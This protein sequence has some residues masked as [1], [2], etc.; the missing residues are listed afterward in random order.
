[1]PLQ[2]SDALAAA[3]SLRELIE[4]EAEAVEA[5]STMT[6]KIVDGFVDSGL[7][8]LTTPR[9]FGGAEAHPSTVIDVCEELSFADGSVGWAY[10]QNITVGAYAAYMAPEFGRAL[11]EGRTAAGMFAPMGTAIP[12]PGGYRIQGSFKFGSGSGHADFIGGGA[13]RLVDGQPAPVPG[14]ASPILAFVLPLDRVELKGNWDVMGLRGTGS[15]DYDVPEQFVDE[16]ACFPLFGATPLT[17][18]HVYG[19]GPLTFGVAGSCAW[20][21]GTARR[22]LA[23]IEGIA[24]GGRTRLGSAPLLEQPNFQRD[25]GFH[26]SAIKSARL[27]AHRTFADAVDACA[28]GQPPGLSDERVRTAMADASYAVRVAKAAVVWA[29]E[30][31]GSAGIRN[32]STLQRCFRDIYVGAGHQVFDDGNF[33]LNAQQ[34]LGLGG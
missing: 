15:Y 3:R 9:A 22:A 25:W 18:N 29:W 16:G 5:A 28:A 8:K 6:P 17:G 7:F 1:M 12:E 2:E 19:I 10:A 27:L 20:A 30:S 26:H 11:A 21:L 32:P 34:I 4:S 33:I 24:K 23:E 14:G 31:S 13:M